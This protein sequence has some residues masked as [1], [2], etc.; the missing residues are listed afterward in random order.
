ML[1]IRSGCFGREMS[2]PRTFSEGP[3]S[4]RAPLVVIISVRLF[5]RAGCAAAR[6]CAIIPPIEAPQTWAREMPSASS[7][8]TLSAAMSASV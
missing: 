4:R 7:T 6:C 8:P 2:E 1:S 3:G 5:N